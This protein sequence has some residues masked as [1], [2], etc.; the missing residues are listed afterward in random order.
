M[1]PFYSYGIC[2]TSRREESLTG[3]SLLSGEMGGVNKR[4]LE[5]MGYL[6]DP[7]SVAVVG[8]S[9][10]PAKLGFHV[11]KS[12]VKGGFGG[13]IVPINPSVKEIMGIKVFTSLEK[14]M[15]NID[16]AIVVVPAKSV[17][18][19]FIQCKKKGVRG[20][21]LITAGFKEIE[22]PMGAEL[23]EEIK[24]IADTANIPVIGPNTFGMI[25]FHCQLNASFTPEFSHI[26]KGKVALVSQSGGM[27]HLL[28]FMA[29]REGVGF[30]KIVGIGNR[31]NLDFPD[32]IQYLSQDPVTETI[33]LYVEGTEEA[34]PMLNVA[35]RWVSSTPIVAYKTGSA[36]VGDQASVSH[37]GSLAGDSSIYEGAF[38]QAGIIPVH[39]SMELLD[40]AKVLAYCPRVK[41]NRIAILSGQAGP[42]IA[43]ADVC[44][45]EGLQIVLFT[46]DTQEKINQLL[47]PLA[48]RTNPVDMGPAWYDA[49][50][51]VGIVKAVMEDRNVDAILLY[52]MF[53]SANVDAIEGM[54]GL[55]KEWHQKKPVITCFLAPPGIWDD[56]VRDLEE[57]E[58]L[59]N[60]PTPERAA[61]AMVALCKYASMVEGLEG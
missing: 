8:A 20:V 13:Q 31:L 19:V 46:N 40:I 60:Y 42:A 15:G 25:N 61:Y 24:G 35:K 48:L 17:R 44:E 37:T 9:P 14:Y 53:A 56:Q 18:E 43:G 23:H 27:A 54:A 47:P 59:V 57:S 4:K 33:A 16:L 52:M 7:R 3:Q 45:R 36:E 32:M 29:M 30:S 41:G 26:K 55:L 22:D 2:S 6:F 50:A 12:L 49:S 39:G 11:M 1:P 28:G 10:N 51:I 38:K 34:R 21:V 5:N 58:A